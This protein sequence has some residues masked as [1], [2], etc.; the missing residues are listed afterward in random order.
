MLLLL[1]YHFPRGYAIHFLSISPI[2]NFLYFIHECV[3]IFK[4]TIYGSESDIGHFIQFFQLIH[5]DLSNRAAGNFFF[6]KAENF[7]FNVIN[8]FLYLF[9]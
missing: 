6:L 5:Y 3:D 4:F 8:T 1:S 9:C 2:Q 7:C